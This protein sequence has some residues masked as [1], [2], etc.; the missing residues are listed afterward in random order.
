MAKILVKGR[1]EST[2]AD[3][4][5]AVNGSGYVITTLGDNLAGEDLTN[6]TFAITPKFPVSSVYAPTVTISMGTV[7]AGVAKASPGV[8]VAVRATNANA[9]TRFLQIHNT[10]TT[11]TAGSTAVRTWCIPAGTSAVP[12]VLQLGSDYFAPSD[13]FSTGIGWSIST[14]TI[15]YT[16]ATAIDHTLEL[17]TY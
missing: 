15:V 3:A 10:T 8:L 5:I 1:V 17:R 4:D 16:A 7:T 13:Y 11:P 9:G 14:G 2:G 12:G 6:S